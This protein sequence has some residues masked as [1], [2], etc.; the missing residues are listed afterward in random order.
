MEKRVTDLGNGMT[1]TSAPS[2]NFLWAPPGSQ[3]KGD[4]GCHLENAICNVVHFGNVHSNFV[5]Y[6][7]SISETFYMICWICCVIIGVQ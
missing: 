7:I 6:N 3:R 2:Q 5:T 1:I 4:P